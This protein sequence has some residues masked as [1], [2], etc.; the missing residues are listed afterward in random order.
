MPVQPHTMAMHFVFFAHPDSIHTKRWLAD[1]TGRGHRVT[2][3]ANHE[4]PARG[5]AK[6]GRALRNIVRARRAAA[7]RDAVLVVQFT[8]A[9]ARALALL[10]AHP[11]IAIVGGSDL[12]LSR[13][14]GWR[15]RLRARQQGR[16][17]RGSDVVLATSE[18]L[19]RTAIRAGAA[20]ERTTALSFGV[21]LARFRP[22]PAPDALRT[23]L[24]LDGRRVLLSN[25]AI[26]PIYNQATAVE[27]LV[28]LPPDVSLVLSRAGARPAT[29]AEV[30][31]LVRDLGLSR[32]VAIIEPVAEAEL[33]DLY[34]LADVVVSI[35]DSDGGASTILEALACGR[36]VVAT[37]L[38]SPREW[39]AALDPASLVP[40]RDAAAT[41]AAIGRVLDRGVTEAAEW[42][43]R[44]RELV[45]ARGDRRTAV[46]KLEEIAAG[47]S[48]PAGSPSGR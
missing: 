8:P 5:P 24:G 15:W 11:R 33:P 27:A 48:G 37:D 10:G 7:G 32:R 2:V 36:P 13:G 42:S 38:A 44:A 16:F 23:R 4:G 14:G 20:P 28:R 18:D 41:A 43:G 26:A 25:R 19:A 46:A 34:R 6:A 17:L 39:L 30:E 29:L 22:G 47:L 3:V 12:Y 21:D 40:P 35:P 31:R 45:A 1:L 9:G